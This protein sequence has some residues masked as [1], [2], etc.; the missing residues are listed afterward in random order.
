MS[1]NRVG[2]SYWDQPHFV[3]IGPGAPFEVRMGPS[4]LAWTM[5]WVLVCLKSCPQTCVVVLDLH[6]S[7]SC[8]L[9]GPVF[10]CSWL[11]GQIHAF[12]RCLLRWMLC[13]APC[14]SCLDAAG[15]DPG[16]WGHCV[17]CSHPCFQLILLQ[18]HLFSCCSLTVGL[19]NW[20]W[21]LA[22][23]NLLL[24]E[25]ALVSWYQLKPAGLVEISHV[26]SWDH[27]IEHMV[28]G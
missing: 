12:F 5:M 25:V 14:L 1:V 17:C 26:I 23:L 6:C 21:A 19:R 22:P 24:G 8:P 4:F 13:L 18:G 16:P 27:M 28:G 15:S 9:S 7:L 3:L 20:E 2:F 10:C 11:P